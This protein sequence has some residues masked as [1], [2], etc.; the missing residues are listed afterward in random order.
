MASR[1]TP[2]SANTASHMNRFV[3]KAPYQ[4]SGDQPAAIASLA[5]GIRAG[6]KDQ[7]LL[8]VTG[9]GKTFTMVTVGL[10]GILKMTT[11]GIYSGFGDLLVRGQQEKFQQAYRDFEYLYLAIT[12]VLFSVAAIMIVPFVVL[13]TDKI[14]D[15]NYSAPLIGIME[16]FSIISK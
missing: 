1:L 14:T 11:T 8:G 15:A 13:Y 7:V 12:T 16:S 3:L 9:S 2:T 6:L 10:W 4:A 5:D